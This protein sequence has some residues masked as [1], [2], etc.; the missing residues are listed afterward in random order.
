[1]SETNWAER[2]A[3]FK[4]LADSGLLFEIN[5][6]ILH[7]FGLALTLKQD[8]NGVI[9]LGEL[10][11]CRSQPE[12]LLFDQ[13]TYTIG[14]DKLKAFMMEFGNRQLERREAALGFGCQW[15]GK[16]RRK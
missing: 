6:S 8:E 4:F 11:D 9:T 14:N 5:R 15:N 13:A 2:S 3:D 16:V 1:M 10:K 12:T 7:L